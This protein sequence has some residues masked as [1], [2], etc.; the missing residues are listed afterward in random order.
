MS[1]S[2]RTGGGEGAPAL[3]SL[4]E[5]HRARLARWL[6]RHA[7]GLLRHESS[8]DLVQGV[9][10]RAIEGSGRFE[11]RG[12]GE[13]VRWLEAI[14]RQHVA[15]RHAYWSAGKRAAG[16]LLRITQSGPTS[17]RPSGANPHADTDGPR[18]RAEKKDDVDLAMK[19]LSMMLPRDREILLAASRDESDSAIAARLGV[20]AEAAGRARLRA[21]DRFR[22]TFEVLASRRT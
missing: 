8:D 5:A 11:Y 12:E 14:A 22:R 13:F 21:L 17:T 3:A 16:T 7:T 19:A 18:T 9:F 1:Q 15:D 6:E 10:V 2:G 20:N 4:L